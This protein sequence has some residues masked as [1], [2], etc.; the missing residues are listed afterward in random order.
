[1]AGSLIVAARKRARDGLANVFPGIPD[2]DVLVSYAWKP[3]AKDRYQIFTM[4]PRFEHAPASIRAGRLFRN[5]DGRFAVVVHV[6]L[7]GS[8]ME[9]ADEK[10]IEFGTRVEEWFADN[11]DPGVAGIKWWL[12][13]GAE[14]SGGPTDRSSIS[15][16]IYTV[17]YDARLT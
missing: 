8:D 17:N 14:M 11:R 15:Q 13:E 10:A 7:P 1:M 16:L 6:E 4:R 3:D 2:D 5:E 9:A 12:L